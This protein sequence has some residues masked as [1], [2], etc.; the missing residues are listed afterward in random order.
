MNKPN[1]EISAS[2]KNLILYLLLAIFLAVTYSGL[3]RLDTVLNYDDKILLGPVQNLHS[4]SK[5][6]EYVKKGVVADI[7]PVRDFSY[8]VDFQIKT[9]LPDYSFHFSNVFYWFITS[10]LFHQILLAEN[11][12]P[13]F[14]YIFLLLYS[15]SPVSSSSVAW[16][17]GRKHILSALFTLWATLSV[18]KNKGTFQIGFA[19]LLSILSQP[20]NALWAFW[21]F[22]Y[23]KLNSS[24]KR[25]QLKVILFLICLA[26][27]SANYFYYSNVYN[28]SFSSVNKFISTS[29]SGAG[30]AILAF[31]RYFYQCLNPFAALPTTHYQGSWENI[32]GVALLFV[33]AL[34]CYS[35]N[36]TL[37][38]KIV[39]PLVFF[40]LP[41][42][43]VCIK[44]T[45]IFCS[46]TYL[47]T[48]SA[49]FY[50]ACA[51]ILTEKLNNKK[52][53]VFLIFLFISIFIFN[54][55][56]VSLFQNEDDLWIYSQKK[57]A[58]SQSTVI[59]AS[60]L[61]Q[62]KQFYDSYLLIKKLQEE[63][64]E[65]PYIPQLIA[66]N[67]FHNPAI[68]PDIKISTLENT[69]PKTTSTY[70]YLSILYG[71]NSNTEKLRATL[72]KIFENKR[73]FNLEFHGAEEK[74][75]AIFF[76]TCSF[77]KLNDCQKS[78]EEFKRSQENIIWNEQVYQD[79]LKMFNVGTDY[80]IR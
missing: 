62:K 55:N 54:M 24:D 48:S 51:L 49:G 67:V 76:Y 4:I 47:L 36:Q 25:I 77:Y 46:D 63:W 64:P 44:R 30:L 57:E 28:N 13:A 65:Q 40:I 71:Q 53:K 3:I 15:L 16:I 73:N 23:L 22:V 59:V 21:T 14:S 61:I 11:V 38:K 29:E 75:G 42:L 18:L 50:W 41:L 45:N 58:N 78:L 19:Y 1:L 37:K 52:S 66:E 34:Y 27:L 60:M 33:F 35:L 32:A 10:L 6:F 56:Y 5:Y 74:V 2:R 8:W 31:G 17:A 72:P 79:F 68:K 9:L 20:I 69:N 12:D 43:I 39:V 26:A 80:G 7:Q 70:L